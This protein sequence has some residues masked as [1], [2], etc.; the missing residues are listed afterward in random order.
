MR[1][2]DDDEMPTAVLWSATSLLLLLRGMSGIESCSEFSRNLRKEKAAAA[3][4]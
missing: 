1:E 2:E 4:N 3:L